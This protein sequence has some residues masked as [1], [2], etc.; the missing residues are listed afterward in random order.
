M[1]DRELKQHVQNALDWEPSID[2]S[3]IGISVEAD[4]VTLRGNV[5]SYAEKSAT[6]R[7]ALRVYGVKGVANDLT[8]RVADGYARTDTDIAQ[9]A[10]TALKWS[11]VLPPDR[12]TV[13]VTNGWV[14]LKGTLE[15]Q[16]QKDAAA[17]TVRDLTGVRGI[18]N[19]IIVKPQVK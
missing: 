1:T 6:E 9:A 16:Y 15:W 4:V 13:T 14:A 7:A 10:L 12:V 11:A 3:D 18:T 8:V 5:S 17:R 2:A 19:E